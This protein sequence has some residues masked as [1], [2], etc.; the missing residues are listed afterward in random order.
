VAAA[1]KSLQESLHASAAFA[2]LFFPAML[3]LLKI[4][5]I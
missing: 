3:A 1:A 5:R 2:I 4:L